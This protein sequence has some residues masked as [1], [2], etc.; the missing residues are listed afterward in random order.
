MTGHLRGNRPGRVFE[1]GR[2]DFIEPKEVLMARSQT[3]AERGR[4]ALL[5]DMLGEYRQQEDE[6]NNAKTARHG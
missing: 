4:D 2:A 1:L 5:E 6:A 3:L